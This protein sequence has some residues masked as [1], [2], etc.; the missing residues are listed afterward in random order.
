MKF[1]LPKK[2]FTPFFRE[3]KKKAGENTRASKLYKIFI[4]QRAQVRDSVYSD[5]ESE[6]LAGSSEKY[7]FRAWTRM[8]EIPAS[9]PC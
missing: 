1:N 8:H 2:I 4:F 6:T 9:F 5:R 3:S 7:L